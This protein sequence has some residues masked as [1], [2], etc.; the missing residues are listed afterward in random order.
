M[1]K[2]N[3]NALILKGIREGDQIGGPYELAK[4]LSESFEINKGL[5]E[6]DLRARYLAW[7]KS[8]AFDTGPTY[9]SVFS[10][11][12]KGMDPKLAVEKVHVEFGFNT[13]GCGPTHRAPPLAGMFN[14]PT[15]D[16]ISVARKEAKLTHFHDD[17][18]YGSA[19]VILLCRYM[20]E[21]KSYKDAKE[22]VSVN[23]KLKDSWEKIQKAELK[24][25]GYVF[26]VIHSALHFIDNNKSLEDTFRFAGKANYCPIIFSVIKACLSE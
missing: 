16:L 18:G 23:H 17:A 21:G 1:N 3:K 20:L 9:A 6:D 25:D 12:E 13:S 14:I 5:N 2:E 4:I 22:L 26:N 7:W 24:P 15:E 19:V 11:V 8:D 10:K